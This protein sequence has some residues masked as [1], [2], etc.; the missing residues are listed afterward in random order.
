MIHIHSITSD[1]HKMTP[2]DS[3]ILF[4]C[5]TSCTKRGF[6]HALG[7]SLG[8]ASEMRILMMDHGQLLFRDATFQYHHIR[9]HIYAGWRLGLGQCNRSFWSKVTR[10]G[11][12][13]WLSSP[14]V[15]N[16]NSTAACLSLAQ[17]LPRLI[18]WPCLTMSHWIFYHFKI[19]L[20]GSS[21]VAPAKWKCHVATSVGC[22]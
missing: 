9:S 12:E 11:L 13:L 21:V 1:V 22:L 19:F 2:V 7:N 5:F 18:V 20:T 17:N 10:T 6:S 16:G 8:F 15:R 4:T 14:T 3:R